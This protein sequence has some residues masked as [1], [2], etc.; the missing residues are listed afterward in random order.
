LVT[1][2]HF[3]HLYGLFDLHA[4]AGNS[5]INQDYTVLIKPKNGYMKTQDKDLE[6]NKLENTFGFLLK[7]KNKK[8]VYLADYFK[9]PQKNDRLNK[10]LRYYYC[11]WNFLI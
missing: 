2:W 1:H 9:V 8:I 6:E 4:W 3:D 10:K 5:S 11:G 7:E